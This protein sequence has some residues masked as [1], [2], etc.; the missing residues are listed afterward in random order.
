MLQVLRK[1]LE[2]TIALTV[3]T[4]ISQAD[5]ITGK[6]THDIP[7]GNQPVP[8]SSTQSTQTH[9]YH[10]KT[11]KHT[12]TVP[13]ILSFPKLRKLNIEAHEF[14]EEWR[15]NHPIPKINISAYKSCPEYS[16]KKVYVY[17]TKYMFNNPLTV[18]DTLD[19]I[20]PSKTGLTVIFVVTTQKK[21]TVNNYIPL[22]QASLNI[23]EK[24]RCGVEEENNATM[25]QKVELVGEPYFKL[26]SIYS[27]RAEGKIDDFKKIYTDVTPI[28][29]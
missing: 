11:N 7:I 17:L 6:T 22:N 25:S 28:Y 19:K 23:I 1:F 26:D 4:Q 12:I 18:E 24:Y 29:Y 20:N 2:I 9:I 16:D 8:T 15:Q 3:A 5:L 13:N 21:V 27:L 14:A 10:N